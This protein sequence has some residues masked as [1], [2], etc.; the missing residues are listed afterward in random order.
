MLTPTPQCERLFSAC[1]ILGLSPIDR[2]GGFG[3]S[4]AWCHALRYLHI[5]YSCH[6]RDVRLY[7]VRIKFQN[8]EQIPLA[9]FTQKAEI[10][11]A[12]L[13]KLVTFN[14]AFTMSNPL[15]VFSG[16]DALVD[17]YN[18]ELNPPLPVGKA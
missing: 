10:G 15:N 6:V 2:Y 13:L 18:P 16:K 3:P 4:R 11:G 5:L 9:V 8:M 12:L 7:Q 1:G 14:V 17:Y